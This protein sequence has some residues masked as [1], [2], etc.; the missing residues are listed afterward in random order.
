LLAVN[1]DLEPGEAADLTLAA[2]T[3]QLVRAVEAAL[4]LER[5]PIRW[6]EW[7]AA[8]MHAN[9]I[10]PASVPGPILH[11]VL[12]HLVETRRAV[13]AGEVVDSISARSQLSSFGL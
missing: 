7:A 12:H 2:P 11:I 10:D 13:A 9:G 4:F 6:D 1:Y 3:E 8:A 5:N